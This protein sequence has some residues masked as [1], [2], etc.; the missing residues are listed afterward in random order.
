MQP[1]ALNTPQ[2]LE[3][4]AHDTPDGPV[5]RAVRWRG[6]W[7]P[8]VGIDDLLH[9]DYEWWTDH[10][11]SRRYFLV[12]LEGELRPTLFVDRIGGT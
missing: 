3:V 1:R 8:V 4:Q 2:P 5:P 7:R 10:E 9:V 11:I 12:R 6:R